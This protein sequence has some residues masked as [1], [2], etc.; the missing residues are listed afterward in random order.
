MDVGRTRPRLPLHCASI[1]ASDEGKFAGVG[2]KLEFDSTNQ[3][4]LVANVTPNSPAAQAGLSAGLVV[5]R[6]DN[7]DP[8]GHTIEECVSFA[9]GQAGTQVRFE[10]MDPAT[11]KTQ[12]A[13]LTRERLQNA[14]AKK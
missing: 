8:V 14:S 3:R 6:I 2:M 13:D 9:R 12:T 11:N 4:L 5:Q 7:I 1:K 10:L